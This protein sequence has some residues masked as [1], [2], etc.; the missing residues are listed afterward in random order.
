[1]ELPDITRLEQRLRLQFTEC[2]PVGP[3]LRLT[4][5]PL[6]EAPPATPPVAAPPAAAA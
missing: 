2:Q 5:V 3:D 1:V 4:A 6:A